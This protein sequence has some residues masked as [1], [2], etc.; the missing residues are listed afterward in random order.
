VLLDALQD[1]AR[2]AA[3][4]L[5]GVAVAALGGDIPAAAAQETSFGELAASQNR[6]LGGLLSRSAVCWVLVL[7]LAVLLL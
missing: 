3:D 7:S 4:L 2:E 1:T 5:H 6:E